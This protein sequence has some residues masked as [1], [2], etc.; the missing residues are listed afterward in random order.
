MVEKGEKKK[1]K[2]LFLLVKRTH[3]KLVNLTQSALV[4]TRKHQLPIDLINRFIS[5]G[6]S[7]Y[8]Y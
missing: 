4:K 2:H 3:S 1:K 8:Q 6:D 7:D 5:P